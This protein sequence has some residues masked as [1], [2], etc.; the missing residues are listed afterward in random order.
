MSARIA[1]GN[2]RQKPRGSGRGR[3]PAK[4]GVAEQLGLSPET[5]ARLLR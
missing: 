2:V 4:Q 1:R 3:K 5:A